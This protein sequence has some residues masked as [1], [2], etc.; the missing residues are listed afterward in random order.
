MNIFVYDIF[1]VCMGGCIWTTEAAGVIQEAIK[2]KE[3]PSCVGVDF[4]ERF[5]K[6]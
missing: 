4:C 1:A 3:K 5:K 2:F 6:F